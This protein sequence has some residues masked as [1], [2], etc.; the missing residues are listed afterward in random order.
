ME[1]KPRTIGG[2]VPLPNTEKVQVN[3][4]VGTS[5]NVR[6]RSGRKVQEMIVTEPESGR[7]ICEAAFL[8]MQLLGDSEVETLVGEG[9]IPHQAIIG[10]GETWTLERIMA[11]V[12]NGFRIQTGNPMPEELRSLYTKLASIPSKTINLRSDN[13]RNR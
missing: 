3:L 2:E 5:I 11:A 8:Q 4:Q 9:S 10:T 12:D 13:L 7:G 6:N 1:P